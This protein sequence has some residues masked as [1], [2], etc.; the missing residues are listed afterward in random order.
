MQAYFPSERALFGPYT[1]AGSIS[2]GFFKSHEIAV[3]MS[4]SLYTYYRCMLPACCRR[5]SSHSY[6]STAKQLL[7]QTLLHKLV[8]LDNSITE[9]TQFSCSYLSF[10][11]SRRLPLINLILSI[12]DAFWA[13]AVCFFFG[14]FG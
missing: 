5:M 2:Y 9:G 4:S 12:L 6:F 8:F 1:V 3:T 13:K 14:P 11:N 10:H 7:S